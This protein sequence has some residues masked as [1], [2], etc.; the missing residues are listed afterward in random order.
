MF[1]K[2]PLQIIVSKR[3]IIPPPHVKVKVSNKID[4]FSANYPIT[5]PPL[6]TCYNY[7][8]PADSNTQ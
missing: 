4:W 2:S 6:L 3:K 1:T 7:P 8:Y 5:C